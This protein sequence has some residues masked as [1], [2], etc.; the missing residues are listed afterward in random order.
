MSYNVKFLKGTGE[1][2]KAL[3]VKDVNT[4]YYVDESDLYLGEILLSNADEIAAAVASI[5]LNAQAIQ[6]LQ[7]ELDSI[8]DPDGTGGGSISNKPINIEESTETQSK[9]LTTIYR[10]QHVKINIVF[11]D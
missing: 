5:E 11:D 8:V 1:N 9:P 10:N 2:Y 3:A 6:T 7:D 4:F